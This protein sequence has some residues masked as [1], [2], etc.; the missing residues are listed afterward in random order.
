MNR[1]TYIAPAILIVYAL[2]RSIDV[3]T[4]AYLMDP[5]YFWL[6]A[7]ILAQG[8]DPYDAATWDAAVRASFAQFGAALPPPWPAEF[9]YPLWT[10]I[11]VLPLAALPLQAA[12]AVWQLLLIFGTVAGA[13]FA[14]RASRIPTPTLPLFL[15]LVLASQPFLFTVIVGQFGGVLLFAIGA[16]AFAAGT[17][18]QVASGLAL[19]LLAL[20]P[21][22]TAVLIPLSVADM[23]VRR[24]WRA[25]AAAAAAVAVIVAA[26]LA[27][28][29]TWPLE[30]LTLLTGPAAPGKGANL[31]G[32]LATFG[33]DRGWTLVAI[34]LVLAA[35]AGVLAMSPRAPIDVVA[36]GAC[37]SLL[38][39][40]Y[41]GSH[42]HLILAAAWARTL[43]V[44]LRSPPLTKALLLGALVLVVSLLPWVLYAY[45]LSS[46]P[47]EALNG[48]VPLA[49]FAVLGLAYAVE[50]RQTLSRTTTNMP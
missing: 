30:W 23:V 41:S 9:R 47:D 44:G 50:R 5:H 4:H 21:H 36:V 25:F 46:R 39:T 20:K 34:A 1:L 40:P 8:G 33:V 43:A 18:R 31:I 45:A 37:A 3:V 2:L 11:A 19:A 35:A 49:G 32:V 7:R 24:R 14:L 38:V 13:T 16:Y 10:A 12:V 27:L 42:D 17:A 6:G 28:R 29:P 48:L 26:S 22:V 15:T